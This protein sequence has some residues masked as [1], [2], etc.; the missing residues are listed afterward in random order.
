M[1]FSFDARP[2]DLPAGRA[3]ARIAGGAAAESVVLTASDGA[4]FAAALAE[5][6][7]PGGPAVIVL[8]DVRGLYRF[9]VELAERLAEAGHHSVA[10]D[11]FGRTAGAEQRGE[12]FDYG[13]H[14]PLT[15][16]EKIQLDLLAARA[17]LAERTGASSFVSLGFCFG[18]THSFFAASRP[19]LSLDGAIGFYGLLDP[20]R[21][22]KGSNRPSP[23]EH[24]AE[25]RVP[26]LGL[27]G[28]ADPN[29]PAEDIAAF[30]AGLERAGVPH[31]ITTYPGAPHSF[32][33]RR[34][35][36]YADASAD[37]WARL[38]DFLDRLPA[39]VA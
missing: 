20:S 31:E 22:A 34:Q 10:I 9:Y 26:V 2:P 28:G 13:E 24:A 14:I 8:P 11:Y 1:C 6:A 12:D 4:R 30:D 16:A 32:F 33:D 25:T 15:S 21:S 38:L 19:G 5:S 29:I 36:D 39:P 27:F 3:Q 23:I 18:G 7:A 17:E 35:E 37:A